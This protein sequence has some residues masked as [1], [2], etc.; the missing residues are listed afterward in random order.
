[1]NII[2]SA[3]LRKEVM[4]QGLI[5]VLQHYDLPEVTR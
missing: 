2:K 5:A 4:S 3:C 1:M